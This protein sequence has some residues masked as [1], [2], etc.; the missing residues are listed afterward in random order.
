MK[1]FVVLDKE[2]GETPLMAI[3]AW[4]KRYQLYKDIPACYAGRLDPMASG[5]LLV[6]L[7][8]ECKRQREYMGLDKEY[9]TEVL[10]DIGSDTGDV[11]GIPT[12]ASKETALKQEI[13]ASVLQ[14]ERGAHK[15]AYPEFSSKT[16]NGK[17]LFLYALEGSLSEVEIPE[18][19]EK[20]YRIQQQGVYTLSSSELE[21]KIK[22]LLE[23]VPRTLEPSKQLGADF[24]IEAVSEHW[25]ALF[26]TVKERDFTVLRLRV[27][28]ASGAYMR[29]LAGRI[30]ES[31]ESKALALSIKRTKI[32]KYV[33]LIGGRGFWLTQMRSK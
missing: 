6:L 13:L 27:T 4:K 31:L 10:L 29:S 11:L 1:R 15:R 8:E 14:K 3:D 28:C 18:H 22:S 24:R 16:V 12:Y 19:I 2:V 25:R 7:G 17:P 21:E 9:E 32:G 23:R 30:G 33:P 20:L 5:K 26:G